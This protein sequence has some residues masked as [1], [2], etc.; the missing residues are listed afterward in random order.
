MRLTRYLAVAVSI[1][2]L[3]VFDSEAV[4]RHG[5]GLGY[6]VAI[7]DSDLF[8]ATEDFNGF[9][10]FGKIGFTDHWGLF[11]WY[12]DMEVD[13]E[14]FGVFEEEYTQLGVHAVYMWRPDK[15][16]RPHVGFGLAR[17]DMDV[18]DFF[19]NVFK[20]DQGVGLSVGGGLEAGSEKVALFAEYEFTIVDLDV[21]VFGEEETR[22]GD[23]LVGIIF[24]F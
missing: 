5:V 3:S 12:R 15:T 9:S 14:F 4:N 17:T 10:V 21:S 24:K 23:L 11:V 2:G 22:I 1:L 8:F 19:F 20:S 13:E 18:D 7:V 6:D 16:V